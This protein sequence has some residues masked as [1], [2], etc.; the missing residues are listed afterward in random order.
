MINHKKNILDLIIIFIITETLFYN[1][2]KFLT[3]LYFA[4]GLIVTAIVIYELL[5]LIVKT[6][7]EVLIK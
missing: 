3:L 6:L 1:Q 2:T 5:R 4:I 7:K